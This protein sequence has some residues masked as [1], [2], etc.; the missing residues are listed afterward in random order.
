[1]K[2]CSNIKTTIKTET[3]SL[4]NTQ[5]NLTRKNRTTGFPKLSG[6]QSTSQIAASPRR[7]AGDRSPSRK[8][9]KE[10]SAT[11][12]GVASLGDDLLHE[13]FLRLPSL[14]TLIRAA[15]TCRA[16]R[17]AVASSWAFRRSFRATHSAPLLGLYFDS[18]PGVVQG[19]LNPARRTFPNFVPTRFA[20]RDQAAAVRGGDFLLTSL[21]DDGPHGWEIHDSRAGYLLLG[22]G[23][24][25]TLCLLNPTA[26]RTRR[27]LG[28]SQKD[29]IDGHG[30]SPVVHKACLLCSEE[31]PFSFRIFRVA[32]D[33]SRARAAV[34]SSGTNEWSFYPWVGVQV[35][36]VGGPSL[37]SKRS[38]Q[39]N[40]FLYWSHMYQKH[41]IT[42]DPATMRFSVTELPLCLHRNCTFSIGETSS[43][44]SCIVYAAAGFGVGMFVSGGISNDGVGKW[45]PHK[46]DNMQTE[47][48]R[49][50]G[51]S[52]VCYDGMKVVAVRNG[53]A[54]LETS[55]R[56]SY[57]SI[58]PNWILSLSLDTMKL[59]KLIVRACE[60]CYVHPYVMA[61]PSTL[62][63]NYGSFALEYG[64]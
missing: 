10:S 61:W 49:V 59:D 32:N 7:N 56:P 60:S 26:P 18:I 27:F 9:R 29:I 46:R 51:T 64:T 38:M 47:L 53:F 14:A 33:K 13:I 62:V 44:E 21:D 34:F 23:D 36:S 40:G 16:W 37:F 31:D 12:G 50:L 45:V 39:S 4:F 54:Y 30:G 55:R 52:E 17:R 11:T 20:G 8:H 6:Y 58:F 19:L 2:R 5:T 41:V 48:R 57:S 25:E 43:G 22:H 42:L 35:P 28:F 24:Q 1:M 63:G 3:G 15:H